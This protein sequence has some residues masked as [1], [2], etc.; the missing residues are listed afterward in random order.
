MRI[1]ILADP[2]DR[3]YGGIHIYT[4]AL[5]NGLA[6]IDDTNEYLIIRSKATND[7]EQFDQFEELV[8][9]YARFPGYQAW[10]KYVQI[11]RI[12]CKRKIDIVV[13]PA[14]FGPLNLP[15]HIKRV[16]VIHDLTMFLF[17]QHHQWASQFLQRKLLPGILKRTDHIITNS[18]NTTKDLIRLLTFTKDKVSTIT[19]GKDEIFRPIVDPKILEKYAIIQPYILYLG[20]LE[21]R[22]N[23]ITLIKA[24]EKYKTTTH[25]KH[26]LVLVGKKG[27]KF[28]S[29][30]QAIDNSPYKKDIFL[31]GYIKR[32]DLP[33]LYSMADFFVYPSS[34]EGFGLPVLEAMACGTPVITSKVSSLPEVGGEAVH[35]F[36][37]DSIDELTQKMISLSQDETMKKISS[38]KG[39]QQAGLFS[40]ERTARETLNVFEKLIQL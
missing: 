39:I 37:P 5:L 24:F 31:P 14:H 35:Y 17:P 40:W 30:I 26:Q 21:P 36:S 28:Q 18:T 22:K 6:Q 33:A 3:Q 20:T 25:T 16:T 13:E 11:P 27:W 7:F 10:R 12:L 32:E 4:K 1:A 23:V 8:I 15:R 9:P 19:L 38:K 2:L 29:I 34:Y